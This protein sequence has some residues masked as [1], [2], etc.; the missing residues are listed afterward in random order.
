MEEIKKRSH[1]KNVMM[2]CALGL[3]LAAAV[4]IPTA[5]SMD[6]TTSVEDDPYEV[7]FMVNN[8]A[9]TT[10]AIVEGNTLQTSQIPQ[11]NSSYSNAEYTCGWYLDQGLTQP[12][13][14]TTKITEDTTLYTKKATLDKLQFDYP[15]RGFGWSVSAAEG[16]TG[17]VVIPQQYTY[18]REGNIPVSDATNE[19]TQTVAYIEEEG[20]SG[21]TIT[22]IVIPNTII[23]IGSAAFNMCEDLESVS[24]SEGLLSIKD[25][26]FA[27]CSQ[28][29]NLTIPASVVSMG[30][31]SSSYQKEFCM[32]MGCSELQNLTVSENNLNFTAVNG[33]LYNKDKTKLYSY[34]TASGRVVLP[35][36]V[37]IIIDGA[38]AWC[39][40]L[41]DMTIGKNVNYIGPNAFAQCT[42][43]NVIEFKDLIGW[44]KYEE[45][46][47]LKE[48][49]IPVDLDTALE[50]LKTTYCTYA[51]EA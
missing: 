49:P 42:R 13:L 8:Q 10:K 11:I 38:F 45:T 30:G 41:E 1:F 33:A 12:F 9:L 44:V 14:S 29:T 39:S 34:P 19:Y 22:S 5:C 27:M 4:M 50:E 26:A 35:E 40:E 23:E 21:S 17:E 3:T 47:E 6:N 7:T 48:Y 28:L 24:L 2:K 37:E 16:I 43:L 31:S 46:D 20:F 32:F 15:E 36:S 25:G 51:K 18:V